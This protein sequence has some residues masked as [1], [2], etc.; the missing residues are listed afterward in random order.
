MAHDISAVTRFDIPAI[1]R[2][3]HNG[4]ITCARR[5]WKGRAD[6]C[7]TYKH[8]KRT[9]GLYVCETK[10]GGLKVCIKE[11]QTVAVVGNRLRGLRPF[12]I[13]LLGEIE[14]LRQLGVNFNMALLIQLVQHLISTSSTDG[15]VPAKTGKRSGNLVS[16]HVTTR[17]I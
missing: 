16:Y 8:S 12:I 15:Y 10:V 3:H 11:K 6:I 4:N 2:G 5:Y 1:F 9:N 14:G 7:N 17:W 13:I